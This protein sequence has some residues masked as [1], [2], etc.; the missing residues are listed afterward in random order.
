M[1]KSVSDDWNRNLLAL[2]EGLGDHCFEDEMD[3]GMQ[4]LRNHL[5]RTAEGKHCQGV[6]AR[7][8]DK[9]WIAACTNTSAATRGNRTSTAGRKHLTD[10][11]A[12][13]ESVSSLTDDL[14]HDRVHFD[15]RP[16]IC[17]WQLLLDGFDQLFVDVTREAWKSASELSPHN[18]EVDRLAISDSR[19]DQSVCGKR[20]LNW[21]VQVYAAIWHG[22]DL[23]HEA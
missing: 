18:P 5:H 15:S 1:P 7:V 12:T 11:G 2:V 6:V 17:C 8:L 20:S 10:F 14:H 13:E 9:D 16:C 19:S 3:D 22:C 21:N 4:E 23:M